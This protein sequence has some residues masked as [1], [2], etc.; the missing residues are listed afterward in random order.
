MPGRFETP[1]KNMIRENWNSPILRYI[2]E[3]LGIKYRYFG[4]PGAD[5]LDVKLWHDMIQEVVAFELPSNGTD[6]ERNLK[7]IRRNLELLEIPSKVFYGSI[8]EVVHLKSDYEGQ[9]YEQQKLITLY[10]LD[11]CDEITSKVQTAEGEKRLRFD[12]IRRLL[13]DQRNLFSEN[14]ECN[15]FILLLT[16]RNQTN[17]VT[18]NKEFRTELL[19]ST[20]TFFEKSNKVNPLPSKGPMIGTHTWALKAFVYETIIRSCMPTPHISC[21]FFPVIKYDG[22]PV[23]K[24]VPSPMLHLMLLCKFED[25]EVSKIVSYPDRFLFTK[26]LKADSELIQMEPEPAEDLDSLIDP[27]EFLKKYEDSFFNV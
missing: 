27:I 8:E 3:K 23:T 1:G 20:S 12:T 24:S 2:H 5:I 22:M 4:L 16:I 9:K 15:F 25:P 10:N 13:I 6:K 26:T 11:F 14:P 18:M 19:Q 17:A 7:Q 21:L